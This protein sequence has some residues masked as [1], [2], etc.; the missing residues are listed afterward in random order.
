MKNKKY[1]K[2]LFLRILLS[3][4]LFLVVGILINRSDKFLLFYKH[5]VYEKTLKFNKTSNLINKYFKSV[6]TIEE[7]VGM[8]NKE[9]FYSSYNTYKDGAVLSDVT[10]VYPFKSGIVVFIGQK[11]EYGQTVIIQ[12]MDGI[13]YWYSNIDNISIKLYDYIESNNVIG[14]AIDNKLYV[15]FTKDGKVLNYEDF[16]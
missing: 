2:S 4:I 11:E 10:N 15:V 13:D 16:I 1:V 7:E 12:G 8:V 6:F 3:I 5:N 9:T 14:S